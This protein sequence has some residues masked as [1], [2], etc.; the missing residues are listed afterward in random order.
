M[1]KTQVFGGKLGTSSHKPKY[2][3]VNWV[4]V[5]LKHK[6]LG[7]IWVLVGI[8]VKV[9]GDYIVEQLRGGDCGVD[10]NFLHS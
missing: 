9:V 3:G 2:L 1:R 8:E 4:L 6:Y 10:P 5:G 7:F